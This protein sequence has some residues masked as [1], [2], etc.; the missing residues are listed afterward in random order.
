M[1]FIWGRLG[2]KIGK[3]IWGPILM[4]NDEKLILNN[5][6]IF[7][8]YDVDSALNRVIMPVRITTR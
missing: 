4:N 1:P 5:C 7:A 3:T 6:L 2:E 8:L